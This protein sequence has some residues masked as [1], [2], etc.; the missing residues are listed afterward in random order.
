MMTVY[1]DIISG[2]RSSYVRT[3]FFAVRE[4]NWGVIPK[5]NNP[6]HTA[7]EAPPV[8]NI[9]PFLCSE[10]NKGRIESVKPIISELNP[11]S[12]SFP[13]SRI[14]L[15]TFTAPIIRAVSS[16]SFIY[17]ITASL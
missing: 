11:L 2:V 8:P 9:K 4:T 7:L 13:F 14:N 12:L 5:D 3:S 16:I 1:S 15:M 10:F 17:G 6:Y